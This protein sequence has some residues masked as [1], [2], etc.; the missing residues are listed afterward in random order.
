MKFTGFE[1]DADLRPRGVDPD[2]ALSRW[3]NGDGPFWVDLECPDAAPKAALLDKL[4]LR[5]PVIAQLLDA[6]HSARVL[7]LQNGLY[8]EFPLRI[9]GDPVEVKSTGVVVLDRIVVTLREFPALRPFGEEQQV[10]LPVSPASR[11]TED[12]VSALLV[13]KSVELKQVI[14]AARKDVMSVAMQLDRDPEAVGLDEII[15][16]RREVLDLDAVAEERSAVVELLRS[17]HVPELDLTR[18]AGF[19]LAVNNTEAMER[20]ID[21]LIRR[22]DELQLRYETNQQDKTNRRLSRL[23]VISA[24]FLPLT[25]LAGIYGMNFAHMPELQL[26]FG[27]PAALGGMALIAGFLLIWFKRHGWMD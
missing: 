24:I 3:S 18:G 2:E 17:T 16:L 12:L 27:Y 10:P 26:R 22:I 6:G 7:P 20:R 4:G 8:F 14:S 25:L 21:R 5:R 15:R 23:T 13:R 11:T 19:G 9:A 1:L